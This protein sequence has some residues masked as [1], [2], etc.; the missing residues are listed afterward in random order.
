MGWTIGNRSLVVRVDGQVA[1]QAARFPIQPG[2][3]E[4]A[5]L[6]LTGRQTGWK[7]RISNGCSV[8]HAGQEPIMSPIPAASGAITADKQRKP[9]TAG[10]SRESSPVFM[11]PM[12]TNSATVRAGDRHTGDVRAMRMAKAEKS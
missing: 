10:G 3:L 1:R 9:V 4:L 12:R 6:Q 11:P 2:D 8:C 5:A 7:K